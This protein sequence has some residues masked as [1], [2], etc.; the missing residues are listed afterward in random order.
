MQNAIYS[1][2]VM[3]L[4]SII[5]IALLFRVNN[6]VPE[7]CTALFCSHRMLHVFSCLGTENIFWVNSF[8]SVSWSI[9]QKQECSFTSP[10]IPLHYF[11]PWVR[12]ITNVQH[13]SHRNKLGFHPPAANCPVFV[14]LE[15]SQLSLQCFLC[16]VGSKA[17]NS[18]ML[19]RLDRSQ[20]SVYLRKLQL[21]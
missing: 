9:C 3:C 5:A 4:R 19:G 12:S 7:L 6:R 11:P 18:S 20:E 21:H 1:S 14:H 2:V 16:L 10:T 15:R 8:D 17:G 13:V